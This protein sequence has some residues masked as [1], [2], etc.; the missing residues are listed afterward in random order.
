MTPDT[1]SQ[2]HHHHPAN[3]YGNNL[4]IVSLCLA[5]NSFLLLPQTLESY[6]L[7]LYPENWSET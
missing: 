6:V 4:L 3:I 7:C 2:P 5:A 1:N